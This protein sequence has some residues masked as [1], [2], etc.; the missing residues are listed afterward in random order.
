MPSLVTVA[1][2]QFASLENLESLRQEM[3]LR[4]LSW[5]LKGTVL[6][7]SEGLNSFVCGRPDDIAKFRDYLVNELRLT[8]LCYKEH[9][10]TENPFRRLLVKI[11]KEIISMGDPSIRPDLLTG[12]RLT[13]Q[14]LKSWLDEGKE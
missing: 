3:K 7:A 8:D 6:L 1:A 5:N 14:E 11:K 10:C 9:P 2:Y 13:P 12:S 4:C